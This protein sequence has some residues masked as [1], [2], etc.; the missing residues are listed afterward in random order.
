[1]YDLPVRIIV[2]AIIALVV[3]WM[4]EKW[5]HRRNLRAIP[6]RIMVNGTRGKTS[7][8]RL[9]A[10]ILRQAGIRTWGKTTGTEAAW[11]L[12]DGTE[13]AYRKEKRPVNIR[14]QIPFMR[15]ARKD[16]AQAVVV[17]CMALH[18]ENQKMMAM[19]FVRP[20]IGVMTNARVDHVSEIG[21]TEEETVGTLS[22]SICPGEKVVTGDDRFEK[23]TDA[24]IAPDQDL[25][26]EGYLDR[27]SFPMF[28]DNV[29]QALAVAQLLNIDRETALEGMLTAHPDVGMRGPFRVGKCLVIN[30]FAAN[31]LDSSRVLYEKTIEENHMAGAKLWVLFNN[32]SDREFRLNEFLPLVRQLGQQGAQVR[33]IGE[34]CPKA[35][36]YFG[37]KTG[38]E[39]RALNMS[40]VEWIQSLAGEKCAVMCLGNIKGVAREMIE[41]LSEEK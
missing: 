2:A 20:T 38:V 27:F 10:A 29:R 31:D 26:P 23:Y 19:E 8:T 33:V 13:T 22:L 4:I 32:R 15:R 35:A 12:P 7:V 36:R 21:A 11:L 30:G 16:G 6:I 5:Q 14:E 40:P 1:M 28:E 34:N 17:E 41:T 37:K 25:L 3:L 9:I 39:A 24:R 18:P